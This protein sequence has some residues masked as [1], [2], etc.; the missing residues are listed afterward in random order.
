MSYQIERRLTLDEASALLRLS[1]AAI[2]LRAQAGLI[3]LIKDGRRTFVLESEIERYSR[4]ACS[5][6]VST[7]HA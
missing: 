3:R 6:F 4:E 2:Y 1:K 7:A 5:N